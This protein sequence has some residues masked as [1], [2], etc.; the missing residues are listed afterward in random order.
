[1][2]DG[3]FL[4][5]KQAE[6]GYSLPRQWLSRIRSSACRIYINASN[7]L[8]FTKF[9]LWDVEQAGNGFNYPI[10]RVYNIGFRINFD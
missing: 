2:R 5:L 9:R 4:R 8:T 3:A 1:M 7:L 6:I 10:Q